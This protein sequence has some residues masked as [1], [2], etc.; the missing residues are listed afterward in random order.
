[1]KI[2]M[3]K[4]ALLDK[5]NEELKGHQCYQEGMQITDVE[6]KGHVLVMRSNGP[7]MPGTDL[8]ALNDF[9]K[10]FSDAYTLIS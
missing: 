1:M 8:N 5:A 7:E 2:A 3:H 10:A 9:A 6:M 4:T